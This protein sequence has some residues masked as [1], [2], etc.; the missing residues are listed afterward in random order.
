MMKKYG[1]CP[2]GYTLDDLERFVDLLYGLYSDLYSTAE[3]RR[4]IVCNPFDR[5]DHPQQMRLV[6]LADWLEAVVSC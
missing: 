3:L 1:T 5:S 4:I 6:D 2:A